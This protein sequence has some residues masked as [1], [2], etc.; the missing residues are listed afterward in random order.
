MKNLSE[1]GQIFSIFLDISLPLLFSLSS[2]RDRATNLRL[3]PT[4]NPFLLGHFA[5]A[6]SARKGRKDLSEINA[7]SKCPLT[8]PPAPT[9]NSVFKAADSLRSQCCA[10]WRSFQVFFIV[11]RGMN[12]LVNT[13]KYMCICVHSFI[14][15]NMYFLFSLYLY[16]SLSSIF[17]I[18]HF[19]F[20][21]HTL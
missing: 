18:L 5:V 9:H 8:P 10:C 11:W 21:L 14:F 16:T 13:C 19:Y 17:A 15:I 3:F 2:Q 4:Y 20:V 12:T 1:N 7:N 6:Q